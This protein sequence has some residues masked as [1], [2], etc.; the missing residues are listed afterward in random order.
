MADTACSV[1]WPGEPGCAA[2]AVH[3]PAASD[4]GADQAAAAEL[5]AHVARRIAVS[6]DLRET[7][8]VVAQA[9]V[10]HLGFGVAVANI[11]RP[12]DMCEAAAVAGPDDAVQAMLGTCAPAEDIRALL[13]A[14]E[15]WASCGF[16]ITART[17]VSPT[18]S[19][20]G[21]RR[22]STPTSRAPGIRK[23]SCSRP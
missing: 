3:G 16:S 19:P 21:H 17:T 18:R 6:L 1:L 20:A 23:M 22:W 8:Q 2:E 9:V 13:A 4:T 7:L 11:I 15:P 12:D 10:D 5:L 14:C